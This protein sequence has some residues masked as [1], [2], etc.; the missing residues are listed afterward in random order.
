M[1]AARRAADNEAVRAFA[2]ILAV[3]A[4]VVLAGLAWLW[5]FRKWSVDDP[6]VKLGQD[7]FVNRDATATRLP[8]STSAFR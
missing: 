7:C 6:D 3:V 4:P 1:R 8:L 2:A 5:L